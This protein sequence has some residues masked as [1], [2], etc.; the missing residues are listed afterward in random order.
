VK[1]IMTITDWFQIKLRSTLNVMNAVK[2]Y[3]LERPCGL[4]QQ[5]LPGICL[6]VI[7]VDNQINKALA[8][9][10]NIS[11]KA[12]QLVKQDP[13]IE[14]K[15]F[16]CGTKTG[17]NECEYLTGCEQRTVLKYCI[18]RECS[19]KQEESFHNYKQSFTSKILKYLK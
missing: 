6:T 9:W 14:L 4:R 17:C 7:K 13:I 18:C 3:Y 5:K 11:G 16:F 1:I 8:E 10:H 2:K 15:C 19:S 12:V